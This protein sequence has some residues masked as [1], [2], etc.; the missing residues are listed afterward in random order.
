MP[1]HGLRIPVHPVL[2]HQRRLLDL[3][4]QHLPDVDNAGWGQFRG[5]LRVEQSETAVGVRAR[6]RWEELGTVS[7]APFALAHRS[8]QF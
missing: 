8:L 3:P 5:V 7:M 6:A 4:G 1:G 2:Q